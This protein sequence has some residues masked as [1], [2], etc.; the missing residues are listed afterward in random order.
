[1]TDAAPLLCRVQL[2]ALRPAN[3]ASTALVQAMGNGALVSIVVKGATPNQKRLNFYWSMLE[4]AAENLDGL[5]EGGLDPNDLHVWVKKKLKLGREI[6]SPSGDSVFIPRSI[7][8]ARMKEPERAAFVQRVDKLLCGWLGVPVGA[9][10]E[11]AKIRE[12]TA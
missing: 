9:V 8:F 4:V 5:V 3:E 2:G 6:V 7:S 11:A 12:N 1:M 10:F